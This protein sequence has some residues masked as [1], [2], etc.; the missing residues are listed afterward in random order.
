M[1]QWDCAGVPQQSFII[2]NLVNTTIRPLHAQ[3]N[4]LNVP[5]DKPG[6]PIAQI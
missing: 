5:S 3:G 2:G 1:R 4:C 6:I